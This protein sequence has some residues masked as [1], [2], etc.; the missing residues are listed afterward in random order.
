MLAR[1][2]Q[3][4]PSLTVLLMNEAVYN[5]YAPAN[6]VA[7]PQSAG[8]TSPCELTALEQELYQRLLRETNNRLEQEFLP[9]E[10]VKAAI[11]KW[12]CHCDK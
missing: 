3:H 6:A 2:R 4:Q 12:Y 11:E 10:R 5:D 8:E 1:A 9:V 7:E